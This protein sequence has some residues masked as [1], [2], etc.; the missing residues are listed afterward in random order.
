MLK[1]DT[2]LFKY[3]KYLTSKTDLRVHH[4]FFYI[5]RSKALLTCNTCNDILGFLAGVTYDPCTLIFRCVGILDIDRDTFFSDRENSILMKYGCTHVRQFT[6]FTICNDI[7]SFRILDD[8]GICDLKAG[9]ICPVLIY[10]SLYSL[11]YDRTC[12]IRT[13]SGKSLYYAVSHSAVETW[14]N[15]SLYILKSLGQ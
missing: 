1:R 4:V 15:S 13:T 7:N 3:L 8:T 10:I 14:N 5:N 11:G 9:Y 6:Q 2:V 12:D